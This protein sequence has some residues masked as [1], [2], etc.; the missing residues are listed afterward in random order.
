MRNRAARRI[1]EVEEANDLFNIICQGVSVWELIRYE[2]YLKLSNTADKGTIKKENISI[3][4]VLI[5]LVFFATVA[6]PLLYLRKKKTLIFRT[7]R[8]SRQDGKLVDPF[9]NYFEAQIKPSDVGIYE[10]NFSNLKWLSFT[11]NA[12]AI[13]FFTNLSLKVLTKLF[14]KGIEAKMQDAI[15]QLNHLFPEIDLTKMVVREY[16]AFKIEKAFYATILWFRRPNSIYLVNYNNKKALLYLAKKKGI[17]VAEIQHGFTSPSLMIYHFPTATP[18]QLAYFPD[19]FYYL[20]K[21]YLYG[22][23]LPLSSDK[24][25]KYEGSFFDAQKKRILSAD[26]EKSEG[27][28]FVSQH[29]LFEEFLAFIETFCKELQKSGGNYP[30][31]YKPHP[32]EY[33]LLDEALVDRLKTTYQIT[34]IDKGEDI[35]QYLAKIKNVV[36]VFSTILIEALEYKA[37]VFVVDIVGADHFERITDDKIITL[38]E[39]PKAL[40]EHII[41][42]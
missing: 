18:N 10:T 32:Y 8:K 36:G 9:T 23:N 17:K 31:Y 39:T 2:V 13:R 7:S 33:I 4:A 1:L 42:F 40:L 11:P 22:V 25:I 28:L 21:M 35:Y 24:I 29:I 38:V 27:V 16:L 5:D 19:E 12:Y 34:I 20:D 37:D 14:G 30:V 6:N 41:E 26:N 3:L 15:G